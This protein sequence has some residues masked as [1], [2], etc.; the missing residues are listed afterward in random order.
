MCV[1]EVDLDLVH[2]KPKQAWVSGGEGGEG[3]PHHEA[4]LRHLLLRAES[5]YRLGDGGV[6]HAP[7]D[8]ACSPWP[9]LPQW[10]ALCAG[11][12][13]REG[14]AGLSYPGLVLEAG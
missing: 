10:E 7:L 5:G 14:L 3:A 6:V 1:L 9:Q 4:V 11:I 12:P 13:G 8:D 2:T